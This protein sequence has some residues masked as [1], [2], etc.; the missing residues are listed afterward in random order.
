MNGKQVQTKSKNADEDY[1]PL[2]THL[3]NDVT[4]HGLSQ[5][6]PRFPCTVFIETKS[7]V[8]LE[9]F[10]NYIYLISL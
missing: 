7:R 9:Y 5:I 2:L 8:M 1:V 10:F 3:L 4:L 6:L